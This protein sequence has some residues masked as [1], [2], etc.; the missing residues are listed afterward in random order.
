[1]KITNKY[2]II[3]HTSTADLFLKI[4]KKIYL[5]TITGRWLILQVMNIFHNSVSWYQTVDSNIY[6]FQKIFPTW[7][8]EQ[9]KIGFIVHRNQFLKQSAIETEY[10]I[11][12]YCKFHIDWVLKQIY[13]LFRE[14]HLGKNINIAYLK[15]SFKPSLAW[16]HTSQTIRQWKTLLKISICFQPRDLHQFKKIEQL[17]IFT[18]MAR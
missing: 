9:D 1:M 5:D 8:I 4:E 14:S 13:L 3:L 6:L 18:P 12:K 17:N 15:I 2:I 16:P 10:T 7:S 11:F